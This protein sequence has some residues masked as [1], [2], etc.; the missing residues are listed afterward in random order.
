[1]NLGQQLHLLNKHLLPQKKIKW[2]TYKLKINKMGMGCIVWWGHILRQALVNKSRYLV[3][4]PQQMDGILGW[5]IFWGFACHSLTLHSKS[6]QIGLQFYV[7]L[8][9]GIYPHEYFGDG[10]II[11]NRWYANPKG[12]RVEWTMYNNFH[13]F[14][15][16]H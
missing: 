16:G 14:N 9:I 3:A 8:L 7:I 2:A 1:M 4:T 11:K 10:M 5:S 6:W 15:W 13:V 12:S